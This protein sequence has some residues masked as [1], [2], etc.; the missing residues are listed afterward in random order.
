MY[1]NNNTGEEPTAKDSLLI[2]NQYALTALRNKLDEQQQLH[3]K[4]MDELRT[5]IRKLRTAFNEW[6]QERQDLE[7]QIQNQKFNPNKMYDGIQ[8]V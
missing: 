8:E 3:E 7:D 1:K 5:V 6:N 2:E 4:E